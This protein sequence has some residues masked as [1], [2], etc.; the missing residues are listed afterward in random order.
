MPTISPFR[1]NANNNTKSLSP[2]DI[3]GKGQTKMLNLWLS[4]PF[5]HA[6]MYQSIHA[7]LE[8]MLNSL[9]KFPLCTCQYVPIHPCSPWAHAE[10][11]KLFFKRITWHYN[12]TKWVW[13]SYR[14]WLIH[15]SISQPSGDTTFWFIH[16]TKWGYTKC[17]YM[18]ENRNY[19]IVLP[20]YSGDTN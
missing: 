17:L 2:F 7:P 19:Y 20:M 11:T 5:I 12:S 15:T 1:H 4:S 9:I 3:K 16:P 10:S 18:T 13:P 6:E 14:Q 8:H